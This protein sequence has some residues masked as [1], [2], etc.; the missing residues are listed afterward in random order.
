[1]EIRLF[2]SN[3]CPVCQ[4][5]ERDVFN[6]LADLGVAAQVIKVDDVEE[7][8][9]YEVYALPAVAINGEVKD[10]GRVP[11][12]QELRDWIMAAKEN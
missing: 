3:S 10:K 9:R 5:L 4:G 12:R 2:G 11:S 1:M 6:V 7:M 8:S